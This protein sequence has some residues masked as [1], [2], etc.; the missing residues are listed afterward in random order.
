MNAETSLILAEDDDG[1]AN[2]V[3]RNLEWV[4]LGNVTLARDGQE[5]LDYLYGRRDAVGRVPGGL[6]LLVVDIN[7]PRLDGVEVLRR[8][9][10]DPTTAKLPVIILTTTDDPREIERCYELGCSA[11]ITKPVQY[12]RLVEVI[13][14]PGQFL[15]IAQLP[16]QDA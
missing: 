9:K 3:R 13:R 1:H 5:A 8:V 6:V 15:A 14:R 16:C 10:S 7:M 2:L 4:G 11:F 12:E